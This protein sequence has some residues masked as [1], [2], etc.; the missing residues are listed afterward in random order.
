MSKHAIV[1]LDS[2]DAIGVFAWAGRKL[3]YLVCLASPLPLLGGHWMSAAGLLL[4]GSWLVLQC[5]KVDLMISM[6]RL[7][8]ASVPDNEEN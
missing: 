6:E 4:F 3:G 2:R 5:A 8:A 7:L 1:S